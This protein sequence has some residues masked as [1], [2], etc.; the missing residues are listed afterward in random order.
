MLGQGT[1]DPV[2]GPFYVHGVDNFEDFT[3]IKTRDGSPTLWSNIDGAAFRSQKGAFTESFHIFIQPALT[4]QE[5]LQS[6]AEIATPVSVLELGLGPGTNWLLWTLLGRSHISANL[7]ANLSSNISSK[8]DTSITD[9]AYI[10]IER[11]PRSFEAAFPQWLKQADALAEMIES[12][13]GIELKKSPE[14]IQKLLHDSREKMRIV[15][16]IEELNGAD[17][18]D[19]CFF[20]PFGYD[21]NPEAYQAAYLKKLHKLMKPD[22]LAL[23]YACNSKFQHSLR[24]TGFDLR[25]PFSGSE[26]LKRERIEF[27]PQH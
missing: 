4:Q 8:Q 6:K 23:S 20:D 11:D 26:K 22:S 16:D 14:Q 1:F 25:T 13:I 10:A 7:S 19:I 12:T 3:W 24:D 15:A 2:C 5:K 17:A 9:G 27:W 21:V 18:L